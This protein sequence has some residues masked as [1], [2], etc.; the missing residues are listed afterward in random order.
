MI[1]NF[2][3]FFFTKMRKILREYTDYQMTA[4]KDYDL[5]PNEIAVLSTIGKLNNASDIAVSANV[6]K[7]LVS[8]SVK[9]LKEKGLINTNISL[10]DKREQVLS[11]TSEGASVAELIKQANEEFYDIVFK[12]FDNNEKLVLKALISLMLKNL[13]M[14]DNDEV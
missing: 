11:L 1:D 2:D 3:S 8:R 9:V 6:S 13:A 14:G 5:S 7:A 10:V 12:S 4:L